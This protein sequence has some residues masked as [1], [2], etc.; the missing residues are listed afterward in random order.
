MEIEKTTHS[1]GSEKASLKN[2]NHQLEK[3]IGLQSSIRVV[4][5]QNLSY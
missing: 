1:G 2:R 5:K 4:L 3:E